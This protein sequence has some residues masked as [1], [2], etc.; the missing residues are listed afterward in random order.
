MRIGVFTDSTLNLSL[1]DSLDRYVD[2]G[3]EAVEIGTG[4][5]S[6]A[7]HLNLAEMLAD[8]DARKRLLATLERRGLTLSALNCSGN[9][10]HPRKDVAA[11]DSGV[12]RDTIR[13]ASE[14]GIDR[15]VTMSGCP[16]APGG[17]E[18]P[19]WVTFTWPD[20]FNEL[21]QWQWDEVITPYWRETA[22]FAKAH[23]VLLC[24]EMHPGMSVYNTASLL[25]LRA[26]AGESIAAN[27]DPS[28]LWWQGMDPLEVVRALGPAVGFVHAKDTRIDPRNTAINGCLDTTMP[29]V[30]GRMPWVFRA[31][32]YGHGESWWRDFV[33]VLRMEGY[34]GVLSIEQEDPLMG[35]EEG[36]RKAAEFLKPI[37]FV[38]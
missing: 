6:P 18:H 7:P 25:R 28:H 14:L 4:N 22:A 21:L 27:L 35:L 33:S 37:L 19:N 10:I 13:L 26:A 12:I 31:V 3:I 5:F 23:G 32:G 29:Q 9:P 34:D 30:P 36:T 8:A 1:E 20:H 17:G 16:G 11:H 24:F 15:I 2:W 38:G